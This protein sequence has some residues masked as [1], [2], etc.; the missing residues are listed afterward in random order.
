VEML[1]KFQPPIDHRLEES[2]SIVNWLDGRV[3]GMHLAVKGKGPT[4]VQLINI[5]IHLVLYRIN[6]FFRAPRFWQKQESHYLDV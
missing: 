4:L 5:A 6:K 3:E 1:K 2:S